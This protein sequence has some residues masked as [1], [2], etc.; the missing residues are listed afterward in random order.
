M[1]YLLSTV[2]TAPASLMRPASAIKSVKL[3]ILNRH[4]SLPHFERKFYHFMMGMVCFSLYA[5]LVEK[6]TALLLLALIGGPL[7]VL[8]FLRLKSPEMNDV[9]LRLFG[10]IMRREELKSVSG[11]SFFVIG[12]FTVVAIFPKPIVLLSVIYLAIGDPV[13]A[14]VGSLYGRHKLVGKKSLEGALANLG[15]TAIATLL[16]GTGYFGMPLEK[17]ILFGVMG[18]T[19]SVVAELL[20]APIDDNFTIPVASSLLLSVLTLVIPFFN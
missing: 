10:K 11:N 15:S 12:L 4:R 17:A 16:M 13:A 20:P 8:D 14:V 19:V 5:F 2:L 1:K 9:A 7:V 18:G 6:T 3:E